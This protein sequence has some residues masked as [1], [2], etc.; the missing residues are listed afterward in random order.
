MERRPRD[1]LIEYAAQRVR[2]PYLVLLAPLVQPAVEPFPCPRRPKLES[3]QGC[4]VLGNVLLEPVP[5]QA[6]ASVR[7]VKVDE[8]T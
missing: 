2:H 4:A 6:V 7:W 1:G 3:F 8:V 5:R